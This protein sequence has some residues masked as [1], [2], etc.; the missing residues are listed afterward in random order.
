MEA[1]VIDYLTAENK[2]NS[3]YEAHGFRYAASQQNELCT[4][5]GKFRKRGS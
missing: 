3:L 2:I 4:G 1:V 5:P